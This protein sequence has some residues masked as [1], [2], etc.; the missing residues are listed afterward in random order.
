MTKGLTIGKDNRNILETGEY[1]GEQVRKIDGFT[2]YYVT[3]SGKVYSVKKKGRPI[4]ISYEVIVSVNGFRYKSVQLRVGAM[5]FRRYVH[6][7]VYEAFK[8]VRLRKKDTVFFKDYNWE[9][10]S[11]DNL[12]TKRPKYILGKNEKWIEGFEG[13]YFVVK[14]DV[15]SVVNRDDPK[16]L[17]PSKA[18]SGKS[19]FLYNLKGE[20]TLFRLKETD[21]TE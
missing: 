4:E 7:L 16:K 13:L 15:Y 6:R 9:N 10:C 19:Y 2:G 11:V 1:R 17:I 18:Y 3:E 12:T 5:V 14:D 8:G 20:R 21:N